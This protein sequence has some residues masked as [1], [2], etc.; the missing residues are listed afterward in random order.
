[1]SQVAKQGRSY[2]FAKLGHKCLKEFCIAVLRA[3]AA[4]FLL[5][6]LYGGLDE[7]GQ[8][9]QVTRNADA[10]DFIADA[11]GASVVFLAPLFRLPPPREPAE[12]S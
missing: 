5:A 9:Y 1:M 7:F 12:S 11:V 6:C 3:A 2:L 10:A 8:R 4:A